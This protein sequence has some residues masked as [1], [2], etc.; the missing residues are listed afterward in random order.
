MLPGLQ[1][2]R[3]IAWSASQ[4]PSLPNASMLHRWQCRP[5]FAAAASRPAIAACVSRSPNGFWAIGSTSTTSPGTHTV[6][7]MAAGP[8]Q[9]TTGWVPRTS[10]RSSST[11]FVGGFLWRAT[12]RLAGCSATGHPP[13]DSMPREQ[14]AAV[15]GWSTLLRA[16]VTASQLST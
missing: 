5:Q 11:T 10:R 6:W 4:R 1:A 2:F 13:R 7:M 9:P 15:P 8:S 16:R 3:W 12:M 14:S